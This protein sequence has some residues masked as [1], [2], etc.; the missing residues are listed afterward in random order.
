MLRNLAK[1]VA[2]MTVPLLIGSSLL[3]SESKYS[4]YIWGNGHYQAR[5]DALL[6]FKNYYPKKI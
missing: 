1:R 2:I 5:P 6:Q 3:C 4:I